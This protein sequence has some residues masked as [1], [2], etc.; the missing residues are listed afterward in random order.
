[1]NKGKV[2]KY[3][4]KMKNKKKKLIYKQKKEKNSSLNPVSELF[5]FCKI[6][7]NPW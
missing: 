2:R 7:S 6:L 1:M 5:K 3:I 4:K